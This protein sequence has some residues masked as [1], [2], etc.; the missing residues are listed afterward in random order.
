[1]AGIVRRRGVTRDP[2]ESLEGPLV[3]WLRFGHGPGYAPERGHR[4]RASGAGCPAF[5]P[6]L[7]RQAVWGRRRG[8]GHL[9]LVGR[10]S[11]ALTNLD[12]YQLSTLQPAVDYDRFALD[13][14]GGSP[15]IARV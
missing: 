5:R 7:L 14:G 13:R 12:Y 9:G 1:M 11:G 6:P 15:S 4:P 2:E 3:F 10:G 8:L